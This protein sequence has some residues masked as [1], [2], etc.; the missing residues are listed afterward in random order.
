MQL[1]GNTRWGSH[2]FMLK[3]MIKTRPALK[4]LVVDEKFNDVVS[5]NPHLSKILDSSFWVELNGIL[6]VLKPIVDLIYEIEGNNP[7]N[8]R[9]IPSLNTMVNT[10]L[11]PQNQGM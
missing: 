9:V 2:V 11:N 7:G 3:N 5:E 4:K 6:G 1:P 10:L 8:W